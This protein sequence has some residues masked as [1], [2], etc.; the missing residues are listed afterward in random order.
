MYK[1]PHSTGGRQS[2]ADLSEPLL[3]RSRDAVRDS[4]PGGDLADL[5]GGDGRPRPAKVAARGLLCAGHLVRDPAVLYRGRAGAPE[6][7][8]DP[9]GVVPDDGLAGAAAVRP[10]DDSGQ[11]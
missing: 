4:R 7:A 1:V 6:R 2:A 8:Q 11:G 5:P 3:L 9:D 10:E